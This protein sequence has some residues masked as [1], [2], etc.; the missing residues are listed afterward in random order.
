MSIKPIFTSYPGYGVDSTE[1]MGYSQAVKLGN[2]HRH[3][4]QKGSKLKHHNTGCFHRT[5]GQY[6]WQPDGTLP[7]DAETQIFRAFENVM[8]A[9]KSA[10]PKYEWQH[11]F[12]IKSYHIDVD[13][14]LPKM[15]Q[16]IK[17]RMPHRP[18]WMCTG[19][20]YV[21]LPGLF[22]KIEAEAYIHDDN[23]GL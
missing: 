5:L 10:N 16:E 9:L 23:C 12:C 17:R 14:Q 18:V 3:C 20:P 8:Q 7:R 6:G 2:T 1:L 11:V 21:G 22:L 19:I 13:T 4:L 15:I